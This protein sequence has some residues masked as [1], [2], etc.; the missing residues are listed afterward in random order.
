MLFRAHAA[1]A[2]G[3]TSAGIDC[4]RRVTRPDFRDRLHLDALSCASQGCRK[5][6]GSLTYHD[7]SVLVI[8]VLDPQMHRY[9]KVLE[10]FPALPGIPASRSELPCRFYGNYGRQALHS[11]HASRLESPHALH[12]RLY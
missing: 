11:A 5:P 4:A 1:D 3:E 9:Q 12:G 10:D 8:H 7:G 2:Q 6:G